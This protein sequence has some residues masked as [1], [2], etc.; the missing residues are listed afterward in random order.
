MFSGFSLFF[1]RIMLCGFKFQIALQFEH[2]ASFFQ[3]LDADKNQ[4]P[5][6]ASTLPLGAERRGT[7]KSFGWGWVED[8]MECK[9]AVS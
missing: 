9:S 5:F 1:K 8:G 3:V 7:K 4:P 2:L 6:L